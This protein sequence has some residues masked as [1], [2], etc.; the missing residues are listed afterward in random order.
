[1]RGRPFPSDFEGFVQLPPM[2]HDESADAAIRIRAAYNRENGKQQDV[3]QLI[4]F[5]FSATWVR[6]CREERKKTFE[7]LQGNLRMIRSPHID[8]ELFVPGNPQGCSTLYIESA[9][10]HVLTI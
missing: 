1:M 3:R 9:V 10:Q 8:S 5:A 2:H 7:R 6:D 4:K